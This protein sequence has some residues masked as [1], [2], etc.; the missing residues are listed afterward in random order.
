MNKFIELKCKH[1]KTDLNLII[2]GMKEE[3][4]G[5]LELLIEELRNKLQLEIT[6]LIKAKRLGKI[7]KYKAK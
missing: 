5:M 6:C 4:D 7:I 1:N 2:F 3:K